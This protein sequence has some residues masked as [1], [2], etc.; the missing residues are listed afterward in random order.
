M[1]CPKCDS[2]TK[3]FNSGVPGSRYRRLSKAIN[4]A[5]DIV[6]QDCPMRVRERECPSCGWCTET[7]ELP[8]TS[9]VRAVRLWKEAS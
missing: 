7:I 9:L 8:L 3:V 6:D 4:T 2:M 1:R 5:T